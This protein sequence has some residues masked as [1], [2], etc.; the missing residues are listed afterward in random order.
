MRTLT[1]DFVLKNLIAIGATGVIGAGCAT[2][3][4]PRDAATELAL[5]AAWSPA[6]CPAASA[7]DSL[8]AQVA[9][10]TALRSLGRLV[11][12]ASRD[13]RWITSRDGDLYTLDLG[14]GR[15][16]RLTH[17]DANDA[18]PVWSRDG[19]RIAFSSARDNPT[20]S[21]RTRGAQWE[22]YT[23]GGDGTD[24]RRLT[25]NSVADVPSTYGPGDRLLLFSSN[26]DGRRHLFT[27]ALD[28]S[29][30]SQ[31]TSGASDELQGDLSPD[32][33]RIAYMSTRGMSDSAMRAFVQ[34]GNV[35][36]ANVDGTDTRQHT[37]DGH[38]G[39]PEFSPDGRSIAFSSLRDGQLRLYLMNPDGSNVRQLT[40]GERYSDNPSWSPD[41][42]WVA[43]ETDRIAP[44]HFAVFV[45]R[46]DGSG[47]EFPLLYHP[48]WRMYSANWA[49]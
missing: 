1:P 2:S 18:I 39:T 16:R 34:P 13:F 15:V 41:G 28:G 8:P 7:S 37:F 4:A 24:V 14:T 22:I 45:V 48:C 11:F 6:S 27:M 36:T 23:M 9:V 10:P 43:F 44:R 42:R 20:D 32:G 49:K 46:T 38:S 26:R 25:S 21:A 17:N 35:F 12:Y 40:R 33:R 5:R 31:L 29:G 19:R 30:V 3:P 47:Q